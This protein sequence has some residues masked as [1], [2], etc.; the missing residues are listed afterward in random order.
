MAVAGACRY[1]RVTYWLSLVDLP[2]T[3]ACHCLD[4]Q[5]SS[6]SAFALNAL[7]PEGVIRVEG[8]LSTYEQ[9]T[10]GGGRLTQQVCSTCHTPIL[11]TTDAAPGGVVLQAGTL[12]DSQGL[13]PAAHIW[14]SRMQ[15]WIQLPETV[16]RFE[17]NPT[18]E[19]FA[20][21]L[22]TAR[23]RRG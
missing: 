1:G 13:D 7:L 19:A 23:E 9:G 20:A 22:A 15:P 16:A 11:R 12:H 14:T 17:Q 6:G 10:I 2:P 4:C 18:R 21:A 5:T 3:Y 8:E